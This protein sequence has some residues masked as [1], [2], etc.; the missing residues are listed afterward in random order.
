MNLLSEYATVLATLISAVVGGGAVQVYRTYVSE[1][2]RDRGQAFDQVASASHRME[3]RLVK[4]ENRVDEQG[5]KLRE[6]ERKLNRSQIRET[7]MQAAIDELVRRIDKLIERLS[8]HERIDDTEREDLR[9]VP[10]IDQQAPGTDQQT[11]GDSAP[12]E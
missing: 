12:S 11:S 3:E 4:V 8:Q 1:T 7:E 2:R 5:K 10:F 6:A 9:S